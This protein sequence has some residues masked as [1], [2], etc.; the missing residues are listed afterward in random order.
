MMIFESIS[1]L[2]FFIE[3][4]IIVFNKNYQQVYF[5]I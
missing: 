2:Q 1:L 4:L 5:I 3:L